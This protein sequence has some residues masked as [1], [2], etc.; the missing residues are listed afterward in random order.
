MNKEIVAT[1]VILNYPALIGPQN[2][3]GEKRYQTLIMIAKTDDELLS[4]VSDAIDDVIARES[5]QGGKFA[6]LDDDQK[7]QIALA[8]LHDADAEK[9]EA[10]ADHYYMRVST[11]TKPLVINQEREELTAIDDIY[12]GVI[13]SVVFRLYAYSF[14]PRDADEI[15]YGIKGELIGLVK[16]ADSKRINNAI[17][18]TSLLDK[19][20]R[21]TQRHDKA[22]DNETNVDDTGYINP[23]GKGSDDGVDK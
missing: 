4:E 1:N 22:A 7:E 9:N 19:V 6:K 12:S 23:F 5:I 17:S 3:N 14:A 8:T 2:F 10:M 20:M 15:K 11:K 21:K 18:A 16:I 13:A